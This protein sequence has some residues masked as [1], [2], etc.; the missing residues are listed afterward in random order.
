MS[1]SVDLQPVSGDHDIPALGDEQDLEGR[2]GS[3]TARHVQ[4]GRSLAPIEV[5]DRPIGPP[6][7]DDRDLQSGPIG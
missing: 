5:I 6:K 3:S 2:R 4:P 1:V 7:D